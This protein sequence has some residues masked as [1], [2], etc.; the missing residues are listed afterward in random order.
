MALVQVVNSGYST[1]KQLMRFIGCLFIAAAHWQ[2]LVH[3]VHVAGEE[4]IAADALSRDNMH[5]FFQVAPQAYRSPTPI[6]PAVLELLVEYQP[7]W[8]SPVWVKLFRNYLRQV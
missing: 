5:L 7:D 1:D 3:A 4:N 2:L 8:L 6:P